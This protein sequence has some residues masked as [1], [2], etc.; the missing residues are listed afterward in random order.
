[1]AMKEFQFEG[2]TYHVDQRAYD[3]G[4]VVLPD[5]RLLMVRHWTKMKQG[6]PDDL[7]LLGLTVDQVKAVVSAA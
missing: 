7:I 1:M 6:R 3:D 2:K 5:G 4:F